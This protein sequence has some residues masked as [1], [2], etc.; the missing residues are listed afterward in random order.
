MSETADSKLKKP[1]PKPGRRRLRPEERRAELLRAAL[2]VL[3]RQGLEARVE[4]VT[5]EARAA[6]GTFYLYFP[7][8]EDLLIQ[9]REH[10]AVTYAAEMR[11]RFAKAVRIDWW[12]AFEGECVRFVDFIGQLGEAHQA[13]YHGPVADR[14]M[15][16]EV[17][18]GAFIASLLKSGIESGACRKVRVESAAGLLFAVLHTTA[19]SIAHLGHRRANLEA[20]LDLLRSWLRAPGW[21]PAAGKTLSS[22]ERQTK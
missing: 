16:A 17:S 3:R 22:K 9:V 19:D 8:W 21:K 18:S 10:I 7:S 4:D 5:K 2:R 12:G 11:E 6:K 15:Q 13:V 1:S 20:M 14:P